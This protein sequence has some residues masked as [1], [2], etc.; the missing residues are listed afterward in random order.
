MLIIFIVYSTESIAARWLEYVV[1][2]AGI[3]PA[4]AVPKTAVLS[5]ERQAQ[6]VD[7]ILGLTGALGL[8]NAAVVVGKTV[9]LVPQL[10]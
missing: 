4:L 2:L 5:V 3:E 9:G 6:R 7:Y 10:L 8:E 1:R